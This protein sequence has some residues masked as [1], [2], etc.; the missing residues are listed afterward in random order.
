M[1]GLGSDKNHILHDWEGTSPVFNFAGRKISWFHCSGATCVCQ[2]PLRCITF[3]KSPLL[4]P[5]TFTF[6]LLLHYNIELGLLVGFWLVDCPNQLTLITWIFQLCSMTNTS[7]KY[8]RTQQGNLLDFDNVTLTLY[9]RIEW[10]ANITI[11]PLKTKFPLQT[12]PYQA[13]KC[14]LVEASRTGRDLLK[15]NLPNLIS[16]KFKQKTKLPENGLSSEEK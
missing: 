12:I 15:G 14:F 3:I 5:S 1:I 6:S 4:S 9:I 7:V 11:A 10:K 2:I 13:C 16:R 8:E